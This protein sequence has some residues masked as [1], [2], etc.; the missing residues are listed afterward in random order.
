MN[1]P[2]LLD[3]KESWCKIGLIPW[4]YLS[5]HEQRAIQNHDQSFKELARRGGLHPFEL[6]AVWEN[7]SYRKMSELFPT[8]DSKIEKFNS[9]LREKE[10]SEIIQLREKLNQARALLIRVDIS[11]DQ[12]SLQSEISSF[13]SSQ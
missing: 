5:G 1:F 9:L 8:Q 12:E 11:S 10:G 3:H 4:S 6:I 7:I 2:L 13:L